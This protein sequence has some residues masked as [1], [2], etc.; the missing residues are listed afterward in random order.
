MLSDSQTY[1]HTKFNENRLS[2]FGGVNY[3]YRD[4]RL[5]DKR[6]IHL[7][8]T[9]NK[10]ILFERYILYVKYISNIYYSPLLEYASPYLRQNLYHKM[11]DFGLLIPC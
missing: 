2:R 3:I 1:T 7:D 8:D 9:D 6:P 10:V 4:T 5:I 11:G